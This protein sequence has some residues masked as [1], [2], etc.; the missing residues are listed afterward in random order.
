M[1]RLEK[2]YLNWLL[3]AVTTKAEQKTWNKVFVTLYSTDFVSYDEFDDNLKENASGLREDFYNFSKTACKL[4]DIYGEIDT[5][6]SILEIM[7]YLATRIENTIMS[8]NE[9]GDRTGMWFWYMMESLDIIQYNDDRFEE[10]EVIQRLD[11]FVERRYE[12]NGFGGLFT[13]EDRKIDARK[14]NIWQQ[15]MSFVTNFAKSNGELF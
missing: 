10:S 14:T 11:N 8:N 3:D 6:T 12:K 5:E 15:A 7:V 2:L 1:N 4:I 13:L 9:Y